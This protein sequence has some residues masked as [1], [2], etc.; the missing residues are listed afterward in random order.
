MKLKV[1]EL[2]TKKRKTAY[3]LAQ[4][5]G[6]GRTAYR[7]AEEG[8]VIERIEA[9]NLG[10]VCEALGCQPGDILIWEP[11]KPRGETIAHAQT[12]EAEAH[13]RQRTRCPRSLV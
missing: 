7:Y 5:T 11:T 10:L 12:K 6:L 8:A 2:L 4:Q 1:F 13:R 3:W 9:R